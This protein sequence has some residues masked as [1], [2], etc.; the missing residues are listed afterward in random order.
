MWKDY[1]F[2]AS[3]TATESP[4]R[5]ERWFG[6]GVLPQLNQADGEVVLQEN[7]QGPLLFGALNWQLVS[8][9]GD[10]DEVFPKGLPLIKQL[11]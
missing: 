4:L 8:G 3:V 6:P 2:R 11:G 5:N 1:K 10:V 9:L 7:K